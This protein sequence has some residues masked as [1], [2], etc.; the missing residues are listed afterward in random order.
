MNVFVVLLRSFLCCQLICKLFQAAL[1][2]HSPWN[3][4][5]R[6]L[7]CCIYDDLSCIHIST[8]KPYLLLVYLAWKSCINIEAVLHIL[9]ERVLQLIDS[10]FETKYRDKGNNYVGSVA[11]GIMCKWGIVDWFGGNNVFLQDALPEIPHLFEHEQGVWLR[12]LLHQRNLQGKLNLGNI[13]FSDW[14]RLLL[15]EAE[16]FVW[17][18]RCIVGDFVYDAWKLCRF[19]RLNE[20]YACTHLRL[21]AI[22]CAGI[23]CWHK[24]IAARALLD[25]ATHLQLWGAPCLR[26]LHQLLYCRL[27]ISPAYTRSSLLQNCHI[28]LQEPSLRSSAI[29]NLSSS[30]QDFTEDNR[31]RESGLYSKLKAFSIDL[32]C[33]SH[34]WIL[35]AQP[36]ARCLWLWPLTLLGH[37]YKHWSLKA[38]VLAA[39]WF[40]LKSNCFRVSQGE[41]PPPTPPSS[42]PGAPA[43]GAV[44]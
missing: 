20:R 16:N 28:R 34:C 32:K 37:A 21:Y 5:R 27:C 31:L 38:P 9:N 18:G 29:S 33:S 23:S 25:K 22:S 6:A 12:R 44:T 39:F 24:L 4:L 40:L 8:F 30:R 13:V 43:Q 42:C 2:L 26:T 10:H 14:L 1:G 36:L 15:K 17:G 41:T 11:S 19:Q 7:I 35:C 3:A